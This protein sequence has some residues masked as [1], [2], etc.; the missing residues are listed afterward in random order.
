M[1]RDKL[2]KSIVYLMFFMFLANTAALKF[3]WYYSISWFD[4]LMHFLGG[5]WLGFFFL[6]V[7]FSKDSFFKRFLVIIL[8]ALLVGV[9]WEVFEFYLNT[10]STE[11]FNISDT[12]SDLCFDL[13]GSLFS[14]L[15]FYKVIMPSQ[16]NT[17]Q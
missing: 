17:V 14:F 4:M 1:A 15:Y 7:F 13:A 8:C 3:H 16:E 11:F 9:L 5:V 12:L 10:I 2:L 6:Y